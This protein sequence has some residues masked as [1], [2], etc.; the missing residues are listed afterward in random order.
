[1]KELII[2]GSSGH[3]IDII[4]IFEKSNQYRIIGILDSYRKRGESTMGYP[5]I[6]NDDNLESII[7]EYPDAEYF[8]AVGDNSGRLKV[9]SK[10][11][12]IKQSIVFANAI[13]PNSIIGKNVTIGKGVALFSNSN[14]SADS[15]IGDFTIFNSHSSIGHN[16]IIKEYSSLGPGAVTGGN[17]IL[18]KFSVIAIGAVVKEKIV[19]GDNSIIGAGSLL[20]KDCPDNTIMYGHPAKFVRLREFGDKYL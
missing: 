18:G 8:P 6:G 15:T 3:A 5:V 7:K 9:V 14:I 2:F 16:S 17:F 13:H 10:L 1:M 4:D 20:L 12:S 11:L 19:V